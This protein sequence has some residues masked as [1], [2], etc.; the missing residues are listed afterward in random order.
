MNLQAHYDLEIERERLRG[1]LERE[2]AVL[3]RAS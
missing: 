2:V 1:R 3:E